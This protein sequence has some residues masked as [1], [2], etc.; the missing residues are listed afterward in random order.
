[1]YH[2]VEDG[3]EGVAAAA[4]AT[5]PMRGTV[6]QRV[7]DKYCK[8]GADISFGFWN[9]SLRWTRSVTDHFYCTAHIEFY[10]HI[11]ST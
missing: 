6:N 9:A 5:T 10:T 8:H 7:C 3:Y 4:S 1:M 2:L 11:Q